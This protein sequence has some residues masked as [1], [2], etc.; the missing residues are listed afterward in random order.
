MFRKSNIKGSGYTVEKFVRLKLNS[1]LRP[2]IIYISVH[3]EL[4]QCKIPIFSFANSDM[5]VTTKYFCSY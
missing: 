5:K 3:F 2:N 4:I 1:D